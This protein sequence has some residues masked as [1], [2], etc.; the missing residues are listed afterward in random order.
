MG[1]R[2]NGVGALVAVALGLLGTWALSFHGIDLSGGDMG[3]SME[4]AGVPVSLVLY[5]QVDW[6]RLGIYPLVGVGFALLASLYPAFTV[7]LAAVVL[8]EHVHRLQAWG[9]ALCGVAVVLVALG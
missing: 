6:I 4:A 1:R 9:L 7:V 3:S 5:P 8:R 2:L